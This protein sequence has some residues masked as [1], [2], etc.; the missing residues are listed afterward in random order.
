MPLPRITVIT[1]SYN[2]AEFLERTIR[3]VLDQGYE[4]LEYMVIDGGSTDGSVGIIR[5]YEDR[6]AYWTSERDRGQTDAINK[7]LDRATGG[8]VAFLNS[9]DMYAPGALHRA[10]EL[11]SGPDAARWLVGVCRTIDADDRLTGAFEP[12]MPES[13]A[14]YL[15]H[16][17]GMIPQPS[18]FWSTDLFR[19]HGRF[20][21]GLH[22]CFDY[23]FNC[24]LLASGE[25]PRIIDEPLA[26]FRVHGASKGGSEPLKFGAERLVVAARYAHCL[27]PAERL[28]LR[29]NLGYRRRLYA[30]QQAQRSGMHNLWFDVLRQPWWLA[31]PDVRSA[32]LSSQ[33]GPSRKAA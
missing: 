3:G 15:M 4:N 7:G 10:A 6:L 17:S 31:S 24:R 33:N 1:P 27:P 21:L 22:Y 18:S 5:R 12:R 26:S 25:T 32:L 30:I 11:M 16:T 14:K 9:D 28:Q 29:R 23:E 2:Q 13:F 19:R 8:V 20:D